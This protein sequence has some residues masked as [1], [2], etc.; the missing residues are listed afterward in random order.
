MTTTTRI[1]VGEGPGAYDV[2]I[3]SGLGDAVSGALPPGTR[4]VLL[5][6]PIALNDLV[7]VHADALRHNGFEVH[8]E[9]VPDGEPAKTIEVAAR[10]WHVLGWAGFTRTDAVVAVGGG[11]ATDLGG[12]VAATWLRGVPVVQVP[13]TLLGMVD[14]AVGG[15]TG[16]NTAEGKNLVGSFHPPRAVV[17]DLDSLATLPRADLVAG[18]GEVVKC[19]FVAD[20]AILDLVEADPAAAAD[21]ASPALRELVERSIQVKAAVV[22][23]DLRESSLREILNYGHTFGHAIEQVE[24]FTWRHGEAVSVGL[25]F[26]AELARR[27]GR[28]DGVVADRHRAV[29]EQLGLP[30]AYRSDRW[31]ELLV[32][33]RRDKKTRGDQLRFVVLDGLARPGRLEG[34]DISLVHDTYAAVSR[35]H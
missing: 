11:A 4:R 35:G 21:P 34:P 15:K 7:R 26:A 29:L 19:G 18:L 14:A 16:I 2:I 31:D 9:V 3:G 10:L 24:D 23:A 32:A 12:F 28:L 5:V 6:H 13:T 8:V 25:V 33:M 17:C 22:T 1:A 27:A 20:P 30:V